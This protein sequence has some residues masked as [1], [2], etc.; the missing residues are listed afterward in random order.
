MQKKSIT[1][2][3][4][5]TCGFCLQRRISML[6]SV[7]FLLMIAF[8]ANAVLKEKSIYINEGY[9]HRTPQFD[10]LHMDRESGY[11]KVEESPKSRYMLFREGVDAYF[12]EAYT[13]A[14]SL[15]RPLAK[16]GYTSAQFYIALMYDQ[17][18]GVIQNHS[19]A[20][21]W[22]KK[23]AKL[24]HIDAQYNLGIAYASGQGVKSDVHKAIYWWKQAALSGSVDAQYNLGMVYTTGKGIKRDATMA[25]KWWTQ[26]AAK[27][28]S[29]ALFNMGVVYVNGGKGIQQ[30]L[31]EASRLWTLSAEEG[32]NRAKTAL[33][34]LKS[35]Q[36]Y[37]SSCWGVTA[38]K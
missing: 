21:K 9:T 1:E 16:H 18:H 31:C 29:A 19:I 35:M 34:M 5:Q 23:A 26:A 27:G 15:L 30:N 25:I 38:K 11:F 36:S 3:Y 24:G 20:A 32:F 22:Y 37:Q 17:G 12:Q 2:N 10:Y 8:S 14:I 13:D 4:Y 7:A 33:R 28:D 6:V